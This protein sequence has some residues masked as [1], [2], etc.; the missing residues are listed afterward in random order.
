MREKDREL[1]RRRQR[2]LERLRKRNQEEVA[3]R[4]PARTEGS[5]RTLKP[6]EKE[7]DAPAAQ[8]H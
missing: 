6:T 8:G 5:K 3:K 2:R 1:R 4:K 7:A